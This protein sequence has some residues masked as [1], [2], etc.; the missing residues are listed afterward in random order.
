MVCFMFTYEWIFVISL[1]ITSCVSVQTYA[2]HHKISVHGRTW[3]TTI[4]NWWVFITIAIICRTINMFMPPYHGL[5]KIQPCAPCIRKTERQRRRRTNQFLF[6]FCNEHWSLFSLSLVNEF[7][8]E[9]WPY[10]I[11]AWTEI[12]IWHFDGSK[13]FTFCSLWE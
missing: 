12:Y 8:G 5:L 4:T 3:S 1:P 7:S 11:D 6:S 13:I 2:T 10:K 9:N